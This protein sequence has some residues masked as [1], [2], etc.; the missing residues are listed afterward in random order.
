MDTGI[1]TFESSTVYCFL[2][3]FSYKK[4]WRLS[5]SHTHTHTYWQDGAFCSKSDFNKYNHSRN[6]SH[7]VTVWCL[8]LM[9][10]WNLTKF[11]DRN[12]SPAEHLYTLLIYRHPDKNT[13]TLSV[14]HKDAASLGIGS[15]IKKENTTVH[16]PYDKSAENTLIQRKSP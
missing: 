6:S 9:G 8:L 2:G 16:S 4:V 12:I 15:Y 7:H 11:I 10:I 1:G 3:Y 5:R 14:A 13:G